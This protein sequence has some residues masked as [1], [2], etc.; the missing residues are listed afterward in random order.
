MNKTLSDSLNI[1]GAFVTAAG[2]SLLLQGPK[3]SVGKALLHG[4]G[5]A[6][7]V[8]VLTELDNE[9]HP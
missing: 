2:L 9:P 6:L 7:V 3:K 4:F 5:T 1:S 8:E